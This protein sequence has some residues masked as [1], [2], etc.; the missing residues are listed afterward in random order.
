MTTLLLPKEKQG[1]CPSKP[2]VSQSID[3]SRDEDE[4]EVVLE[5]SYSKKR[6]KKMKSQPMRV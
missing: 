5:D 6:K 2:S 4:E 1:S 3:D